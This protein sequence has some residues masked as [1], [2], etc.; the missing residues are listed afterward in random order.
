MTG[1]WVIAMCVVFGTGKMCH[2]Y[3]SENRFIPDAF[4]NEQACIKWVTAHVVQGKTPFQ[5]GCMKKDD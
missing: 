1:A 4:D 3:V 2:P 5:I